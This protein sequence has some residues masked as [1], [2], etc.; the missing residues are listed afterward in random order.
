MDL[1]TSFLRFTY[2][3]NNFG[4][5]NERKNNG[6]NATFLMSHIIKNIDLRNIRQKRG[7]V[8]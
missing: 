8:P 5:Q 1:K 6:K 4:A 2:Q 7:K 3:K